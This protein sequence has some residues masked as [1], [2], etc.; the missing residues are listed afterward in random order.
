MAKKSFDVYQ[1]VTDAILNEIEKGTPPWRKPW[2]GGDAAAIPEKWN[3]E[4]YAGINVIML[5][6]TA[7]AK[8]YLS[9]RWMT[10]KQAKDLGV[11]VRKGEK[12]ATSIKYGTFER[13]NEETGLVEEV[14]FARA[15]RVF[16]ADQIEGLPTEFYIEP[17]P[18]RVMDTPRDGRLD[19]WLMS[20]GADIRVTK[21]PRAYYN[22]KIDQI[23]LPETGMF[24]TT[25]G[26]YT[27][28]AHELVHW[29]G[30]HSRLGRL[31]EEG[32]S[33][34]EYAFE[35]LVAEIGACMT[36]VRLDMCPEFDQHAAYIE[37]WRKILKE[38][39]RAIFRAAAA[40]QKAVDFIGT[41]YAGEVFYTDNVA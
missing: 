40:A 10:F 9:P 23:H 20:R 29:T 4:P 7:A 13:V 37:G 35:E 1:H 18:P 14:P 33:R 16:N 2:A 28:A 31:N 5:W 3:G 17:E 8:G 25:E 39:K 30:H 11:K 15:Y 24:H 26:Y 32:G 21:E 6:M 38:D 34:R 22:P 27:T 19:A 41:E 36:A 12:S